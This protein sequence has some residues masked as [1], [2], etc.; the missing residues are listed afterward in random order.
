MGR[1]LWLAALA[2]TAGPLMASPAQAQEARLV[3][4]VDSMTSTLPEME[5]RHRNV[6]AAADSMGAL[7]RALS[8]GITKIADSAAGQ[9]AEALARAIH[10]LQEM[11]MSFNLQYLQ[12]QQKM[13]AETRRFTMLSNIMKTKHDTAKNSIQNIR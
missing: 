8:E 5:A 1:A 7:Y 9:E 2:V 13:Q 3:A 6:V 11:N 12:L 4:A 10:N